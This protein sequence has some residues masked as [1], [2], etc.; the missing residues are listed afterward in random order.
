MNIIWSFKWTFISNLDKHQT[1][2][3]EQLDGQNPMNNNLDDL[4]HEHLCD[5]IHFLC[6]Y[7]N[8]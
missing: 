8:I 2:F 3:I 5:N 4:V 6:L 7:E 1:D